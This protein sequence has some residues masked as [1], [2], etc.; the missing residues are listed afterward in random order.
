MPHAV[1]GLGTN[2]GARRAI[3]RCALR[4]LASAEGVE[5]VARSKLY[6][7]PPL[8]PPQPD[9]LNAAVRV[10]FTGK[11]EELFAITQRIE[12]QLGRERRERWG[13]RTLDIDILHWSEGP[14]HTD[15]LTIPHPGLLSR[16][17]ALAPLLD[18]MPEADAALVETLATLGGPPAEARP[19][20]LEPTAFSSGPLVVPDGTDDVELA[21]LVVS[22]VG[23]CEPGL[24]RACTARA[25]VCPKPRFDAAGLREFVESREALAKEG[26]RVHDAAITE[27][28]DLHLRGFWLGEQVLPFEIGAAPR[29]H[30]EPRNSGERMVTVAREG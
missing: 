22:A 2:L 15:T 3:L 14:V 24:E 8:G 30:I 28:G 18:V 6:E 13:A 26:F 11:V 17:F 21:C 19:A 9:Y 27:I 10:S 29:F 23:L 1:L 5:I 16:S 20:W 7:T 12:Q 25:F 4:L